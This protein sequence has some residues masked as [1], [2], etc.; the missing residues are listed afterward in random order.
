[1]DQGR[2]EEGRMAGPAPVGAATAQQNPRRGKLALLLQELLTATVRLRQRPNETPDNAEAFRSQVLR[3]IAAANQEGRKQGYRQEDVSYALYSSVAFL[4]ESVLNLNVAAFRAWAGRPLQEEMFGVHVGGD[5]FFKYLDAL[6]AR[7]D[8]EDLA[9]VLEV[10]QLCLLLGFRGRYGT[11]RPEELHT[12]IAR[13]RDRLSRIRGLPGAFA[14]QWAPPAHE[15]IRRDVDP[16][17]RKLWLTVGILAATS[18][19][20]FI[21]LKFVLV[22][23]ASSVAVPVVS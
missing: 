12:W 20:L 4:D 9:D 13:V 1:M 2:V 18:L 17:Q 8:S 7:D 19:V 14:P 22:T 23:G 15:Q 21:V 10:Y 11:S 3:L 5:V 6:L 16:W